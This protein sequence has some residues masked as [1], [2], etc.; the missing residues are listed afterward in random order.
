M[1]QNTVGDTQND[2]EELD[3]QRGAEKND[4]ELDGWRKGARRAARCK[5]G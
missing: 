1:A 4:A 2:A 5:E 3:G